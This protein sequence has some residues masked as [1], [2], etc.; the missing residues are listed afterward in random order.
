MSQLN[1]T[2]GNCLADNGSIGTNTA[3]YGVTIKEGTNAKMGTAV[4]NS[5]TAV[6]VAT[7]AVTATSRIMLTTQS[8]SGTALGTPYVSGRTAGTSF[9]IKSTGTSDTSTVAWVIFD[10]S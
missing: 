1:L 9:S 3:G 5:T 7:T 4:L 6:T 10:P 8:P 2:T